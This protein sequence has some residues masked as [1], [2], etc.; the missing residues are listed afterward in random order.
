MKKIKLGNTIKNNPVFTALLGIVPVLGTTGFMLNAVVMGLATLLVLLLSSAFISM[1]RK[2]LTP[3]NKTF[4]YISTAA[5][6]VTII[7]IVIQLVSMEVYNDLG[8]Y[9]PL[10]VVN[11]L[12]LNEFEVS[13]SAKTVKESVKSSFRVGMY[14]IFAMIVIA[15]IREL[16]GRGAVL[17][18]VVV[19]DNIPKLLILQTAA[20]GFFIMALFCM[21]AKIMKGNR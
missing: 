1:V 20:G 2:R 18:F 16:F 6:F 12:I 19:P 9:V 7:S 11:C 10:I 14:F 21:F 13:A 17:G 5:F 4:I 3:R 8:I 15:F